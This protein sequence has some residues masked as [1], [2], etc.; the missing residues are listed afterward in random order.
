MWTAICTYPLHRTTS[1]AGNLALD[2][3]KALLAGRGDRRRLR[4]APV[5]T[6]AGRCLYAQ[7]YIQV[8]AAYAL[9]ITA[10]DRTAL[11]QNLTD[12]PDNPHPTSSPEPG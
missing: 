3:L 8:S 5:H 11:L 6:P 10:A 9:P 2:A 1:V 4:V 12:C 7:R